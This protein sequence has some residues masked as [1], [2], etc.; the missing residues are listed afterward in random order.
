MEL[1]SCVARGN[2]VTNETEV[3]ARA[4]AINQDHDLHIVAAG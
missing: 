4:L 2:N 1:R 3:A